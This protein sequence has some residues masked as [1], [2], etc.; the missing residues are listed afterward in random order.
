VLSLCRDDNTA[1]DWVQSVAK[2][3]LSTEFLLRWVFDSTGTVP[4]NPCSADTRRYGRQS[5]PGEWP[6]A[7]RRD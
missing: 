3:G 2:S 1:E 5:S 4:A 6:K 7:L